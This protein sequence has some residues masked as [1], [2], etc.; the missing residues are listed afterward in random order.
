MRE[1]MQLSM[2]SKLWTQQSVVDETTARVSAVTAEASARVAADGVLQSAVDQE[3]V[4]RASA[5]A[6][7]TLLRVAEED[8]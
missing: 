6:A 8:H 3:G 4:D 7:E 5:M 2:W 1:A